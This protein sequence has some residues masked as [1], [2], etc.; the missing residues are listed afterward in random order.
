MVVEFGTSSK[1]KPTVMYLNFE[2]V[3]ERDYQCG[4]T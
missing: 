4:T 1:A 2:Y 3:K